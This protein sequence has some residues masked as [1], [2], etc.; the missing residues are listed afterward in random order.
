MTETI[1]DQLLRDRMQPTD[2]VVLE[3]Q[4][5]FAR[6]VAQNK[7]DFELLKTRGIQFDMG[8]LLSGQIEC[9]YRSIAEV[10]G[11]EQGPRFVELAK[12][13][14]EQAIAKEIAN[15]KEQGTKH[16]LA[17]GGSMSPGQIREL[18]RATGTFGGIH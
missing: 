12:L 11:P 9:L 1:Q 6:L 18:A 14:W 8:I 15:A 17:L 7:A 2:P 5:E 10:M 4:A 16:V 3:F 13:R